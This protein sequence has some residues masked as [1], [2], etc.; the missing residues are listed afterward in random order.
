MDV[1]RLAPLLPI[2]EKLEDGAEIMFESHEN[3]MPSSVKKMIRPKKRLLA[4]LEEN[5]K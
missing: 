3:I 4:F 5:E 2:Y 1:P